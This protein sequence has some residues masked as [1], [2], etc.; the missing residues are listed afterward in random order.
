MKGVKTPENTNIVLLINGK[1]KGKFRPRTGHEGLYNSTLFLTS[2]LEGV[3]WILIKSDV[4]K[5][6]V[7]CIVC[8]TSY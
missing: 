2:A 8:F 7:T 5:Q 6:N 3:G 1:G 4:T